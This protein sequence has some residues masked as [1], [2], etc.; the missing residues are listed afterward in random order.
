MTGLEQSAEG[1]DYPPLSALNH[2]LFCERRCALLRIDRVWVDNVHTI[3]GTVAHHRAHEVSERSRS[4]HQV[5]CGLRLVSRRLRL[6]GVA[7]VVEFLRPNPDLRETP[8]PVEYKHG[9]RKR[10]DNDDVQLCAQA[11]CLEEML[12]VDV[13]AGAIY[14]VKSRGRRRVEFSTELRSKTERAAGRLH[15]LLAAGRI[16]APELK[17]RC[18]GCSIRGVCLPEIF[19]RPDRVEQLAR[20]LFKANLSDPSTSTP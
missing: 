3:G 20:G 12:G 11:I 15:A 5:I 13:P 7:D 17:P 10:W 16:P 2:L 18:R 8:F 4:S 6:T 1:D 14:H 19:S 9:R